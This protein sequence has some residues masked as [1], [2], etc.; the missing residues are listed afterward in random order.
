MWFRVFLSQD[1]GLSA[2]QWI[3]RSSIKSHGQSSVWPVLVHL[4]YCT[5]VISLGGILP[6]VK[7]AKLSKSLMRGR[8]REK[9]KGREKQRNL[10]HIFYWY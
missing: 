7:L 3:E 1:S 6:R 9:E 5:A 10:S 4:R 2:L 8:E